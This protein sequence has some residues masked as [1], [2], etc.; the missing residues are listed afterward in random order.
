MAIRFLNPVQ[1]ADANPANMAPRLSSLDGVRLGFLSNSK[2]NADRLLD[3]VS[4]ELKSKFSLN[5]VV[6]VNKFIAAT[7]CPTKL[8]DELTSKVDAVITAI[9]D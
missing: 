1:E 9:G 2:Q 5:G 3:Y 6:H 4:E 7:N 8:M